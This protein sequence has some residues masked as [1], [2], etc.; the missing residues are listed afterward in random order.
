MKTSL[1]TSILAV[2]ALT[3]GACSTGDGNYTDAPPYELERTAV[4]DS[5]VAAAPVAT[6]APAPA[7]APTCAPCADCSS[8][9]ARALQ[10]EK[11]LAMCRESTNRVRDAYRDELKK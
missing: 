8:W 2:A 5:M 7:P 6:P 9:E 4:H 10:A 3:L 11:D 1:K